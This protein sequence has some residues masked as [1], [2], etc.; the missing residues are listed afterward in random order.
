M[1]DKLNLEYMEVSAKNGEG[2]EALFKKVAELVGEKEKT[3][4]FTFASPVR[5]TKKII[6]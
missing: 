2:V 1:A 6:L 4:E 3:P 5:E